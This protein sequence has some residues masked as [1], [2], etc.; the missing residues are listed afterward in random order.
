MC[1]FLCL[2]MCISLLVSYAKWSFFGFLQVDP[3]HAAIARNT[4]EWAGLSDY[5]EIWCGHSE[6]LIPR[7]K[8][9]LGRKVSL[10][11]KPR[12]TRYTVLGVPVFDAH[13]HGSS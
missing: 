13:P 5:I 1:P 8:E 6:N 11:S 10:C 7:L 3:Y 2:L 9:M 4:I 12:G